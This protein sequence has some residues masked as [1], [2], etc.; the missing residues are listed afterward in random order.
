MRFPKC[1]VTIGKVKWVYKPLGA[2]TLKVNMQHDATKPL[3]DE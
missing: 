1:M 2:V 3:T